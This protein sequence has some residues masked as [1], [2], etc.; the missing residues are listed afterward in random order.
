[1][2]KDRVVFTEPIFEVDSPAVLM[3]MISPFPIDPSD[4]S[5][6]S[7]RSNIQQQ[8][9][10]LSTLLAS[11]GKPDSIPYLFFLFQIRRG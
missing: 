5:I 2:K 3:D 8:L 9:V 11:I 10:P 1:M 6:V 7:L 4:P